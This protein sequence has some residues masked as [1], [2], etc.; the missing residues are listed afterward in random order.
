MLESITL[1]AGWHKTWHP[2]WRSQGSLGTVEPRRKQIIVS[3]LFKWIRHLFSINILHKSN[4]QD[5]IIM[6]YF[7]SLA[8][9][10]LVF[11][12]IKQLPPSLPIFSTYDS[13][14]LIYYD[15]INDCELN[16]LETVTQVILCHIPCSAV[17]CNLSFISEDRKSPNPALL[18]IRIYLLFN[19]EAATKLQ[20]KLRDALS[21]ILSRL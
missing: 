19:H 13:H 1:H 9:Q 3:E 5:C 2:F 21:F 16:L 14:C 7:L 10:L 15:F 20:Q 18:Y 12:H 6:G 17:A 4:S 11:V 8:Y